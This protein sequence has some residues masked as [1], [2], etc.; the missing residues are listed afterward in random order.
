ML[1]LVSRQT[2]AQ[3]GRPRQLPLDVFTSGTLCSGDEINAETPPA[4]L[5]PIHQPASDAP[6][7]PIIL[8]VVGVC[9]WGGVQTFGR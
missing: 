5:T 6:P 2:G 4:V 3:G 1:R 9:S 7:S 8:V